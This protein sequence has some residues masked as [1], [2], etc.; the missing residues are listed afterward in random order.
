MVRTLFLLLTFL[1][2]V[3]SA[4]VAR[5]GIITPAGLSPGDTFRVIFY[6]SNTTMASSTDI[7]YYDN[8]VAS[9]AVAG[10]LDT[11]GGN[12][13]VWQALASTAA[14]SAESRFGTSTAP[15][16]NMK[17]TLVANQ[18][19]D[20]FSGYLQAPVG[21]DEVGHQWVWGGRGLIPLPPLRLFGQVSGH[22]R[23]SR[24]GL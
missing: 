14:V 16:Y 7:G 4:T 8:F 2:A 15:L 23:I 10:G 17:G 6:T 13:V 22:G 1:V 3:S 20:I 12:P 5:G 18:V 24:R 11:Y 19:A 9:A 21:Y